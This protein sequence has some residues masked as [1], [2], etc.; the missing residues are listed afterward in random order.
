VMGINSESPGVLQPEPRTSPTWRMG[1]L[2]QPPRGNRASMSRNLTPQDF[3]WT[4]CRTCA[5]GTSPGVYRLDHD[6]GRHDDR[7]IALAL[8]AE[9]LLGRPKRS[10]GPVESGTGSS[11][12][13]LAAR[14]N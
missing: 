12:T 6:H 1:C 8:G 7:A 10:W 9:H 5:S 13:V 11:D 2:R 14:N 3:D 4:S